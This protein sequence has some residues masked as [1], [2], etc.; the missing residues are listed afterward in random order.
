[1]SVV[2]EENMLWYEEI[3]TVSPQHQRHQTKRTCWALRG[4]NYGTRRIEAN[5][6]H[7]LWL[8][9]DKDIIDAHQRTIREPSGTWSAKTLYEVFYHTQ[10]SPVWMQFE[11]LNL[12]R[13][14]AYVYRTCG[15]TVEKISLTQTGYLICYN[16]TTNCFRRRHAPGFVIDAELSAPRSQA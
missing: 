1:M 13:R 4:C 3:S 5:L 6:L 7:N 16:W 10:Y 11:N 2:Y 12:A 8:W 14:W 15:T 9:K